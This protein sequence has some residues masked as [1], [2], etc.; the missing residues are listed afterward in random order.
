MVLNPKVSDAHEP[1]AGCVL[2]PISYGPRPQDVGGPNRFRRE[3]GQ[4]SVFSAPTDLASSGK[5]SEQQTWH[6]RD[7]KGAEDDWYMSFLLC[8]LPVSAVPCLLLRRIQN[9]PAFPSLLLRITH[10]ALLT[11]PP[12]AGRKWI[13][14]A[15][16]SLAYNPWR[17]TVP[18][19]NT[20]IPGLMR[21]S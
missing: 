16:C 8:D 13:S 2:L 12:T 7:G 20:E 19:M 18:S 4:V 6:R 17:L 5:S 15:S 1:P 11:P 21:S 9:S 10:Y 14:V 3:S